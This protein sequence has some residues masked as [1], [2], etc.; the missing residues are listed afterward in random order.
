MKNKNILHIFKCLSD[1]DFQ[2]KVWVNADFFDSLCS[3]F[4][5]AVNSLEDFNFYEDIKNKK[6]KFSV[7]LYS[8]IS[9]LLD[10]LDN[11]DENEKMMSDPQWLNIV[12]QSK[13]IY[14]EIKKLEEW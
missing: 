6:F 9:N 2:N 11:Y 12:K 5:E 3:S 10:D 7:D 4:G 14:D 13:I 1:L 8:K